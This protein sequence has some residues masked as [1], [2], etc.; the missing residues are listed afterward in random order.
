MLPGSREVS[1][2]RLGFFFSNCRPEKF[3]ARITLTGV[4]HLSTLGQPILVL[5]PE[6][7]YIL[8]FVDIAKGFLARRSKGS[9]V[10]VRDSRADVSSIQ[11]AYSSCY[12]CR[13]PS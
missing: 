4:H 10:W 12:L 7:S 8:E 6:F 3:F 5:I 9:D 13:V 1:V 11:F 2:P